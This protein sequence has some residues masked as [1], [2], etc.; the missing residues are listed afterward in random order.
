MFHLVEDIY[1][2][3][4][5]FDLLTFLIGFIL[6]IYILNANKVTGWLYY[7]FIAS[8]FSPFFFNN[9]L[10]HWTYFLDQSKYL[11]I[12]QSIRN[13]QFDLI[14]DIHI[15][16]LVSGIIYSLFPTPLIYSFTTIS[17]ISRFIFLIA[18]I[19]VHKKYLKDKVVLF[20]LLF[21]PSIILYTSV[22][23]RE[24]FLFTFLILF[25]FFLEKYKIYYVIIFV[26]LLTLIKPEVGLVLILSIVSYYLLF[27]NINNNF[28]GVLLTLG[29]AIFIVFSD[30]FLEYINRRYT[31]FY[32][33]E[34]YFFPKIYENFG[35]MIIRLPNAFLQFMVS[36]LFQIT[37]IFRFFQTIEN[38]FIYI[39]LF[40]YFKLCYNLNKLKTLYWFIILFLN[41]LIYSL[42]VVN[43]GSIVRYK[44][45]LFLF[46][47]LSLKHF[48]KKNV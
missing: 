19:F 47:I 35:D 25:F 17:I 20:F 5:V 46:I 11:F 27:S 21:C 34:F 7:T 13:F 32:Y 2:V 6:L 22:G 37:N 48:T 41:L 8:F 43:P 16:Q 18:L 1:S 9:F 45:T 42:V 24:V 10:F 23:L 29:L 3:R 40:F 36:P 14:K 26:S 12:A 31:G 28:K 39:Y 4:L 30:N 38:L 33:E 44:I 15:S